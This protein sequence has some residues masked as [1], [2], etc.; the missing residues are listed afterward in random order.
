[1]TLKTKFT[2][3]A[4]ISSFF[5]SLILFV[6]AGRID[7]CQGWVYGAASFVTTIMNVLTI[8]SDNELMSERL[9]QGEGIKSWDKMLLGLSFLVFVL[10]VVAA[11][12][13]SGRYRWT[14]ELPWSATAVGIFLMIAGQ[15]IFL[16]ARNENKFFSTVVRIQK[17]RGHT[18][19]DSGL[20]RIVRH[21]GYFGMIISTLGLP[22]ILGSIWSGIPVTVSIIFLCVR[23]VLEDKTLV[24]ELEGYNAYC[25]KTRYKLIPRVW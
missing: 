24:N 19:C 15:I 6:A 14:P 2:L 21:P 18:V 25:Q 17:E 13:D 16:S 1:M 23:T 10:T 5:F 4:F 3:N 9:Q 7:Y 12:L 22:W 11:G 20:Y 8:H